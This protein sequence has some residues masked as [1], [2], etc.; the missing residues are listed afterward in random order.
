M[1]TRQ[2]F[3]PNARS[4]DAIS[5]RAA[6]AVEQT[7]NKKQNTTPPTRERKFP[8]MENRRENLAGGKFVELLGNCGAYHAIPIPRLVSMRSRGPDFHGTRRAGFFRTEDLAGTVGSSST[9]R[10]RRT[11]KRMKRV[12]DSCDGTVA[13]RRV[14]SAEQARLFSP[15][16]NS[17]LELGRVSVATAAA[18]DA[19]NSRRKTSFDDN[20]PAE[21]GPARDAASCPAGSRVRCPLFNRT[22]RDRS[23]R[24]F[25][26]AG[27]RAT[28]TAR[29]TRGT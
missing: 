27:N 22:P 7:A 29:F 6:P 11:V 5:T 2:R 14:F 13:I 17:T 4:V 26:R 25:S 15:G 16:G 21:R 10:P 28:R 3:L 9:P 19:Q 1:L 24:K 23:L 20:R 18:A 8:G 12:S